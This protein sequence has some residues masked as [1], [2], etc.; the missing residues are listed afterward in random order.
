MTFLN[1]ISLSDKGAIAGVRQIDDAVIAVGSTTLNS[2]TAAFSAA[3][4]GKA[5]SIS[6][7]G[8]SGLKLLTTIVAVISANSVTLANA[9]VTANSSTG[10]TIGFDC[11]TALQ[12]AFDDISAQGG[13]IVVIDGE[14]LLS[15]PVSVNFGGVATDVTVQGTG[16]NSGIYVAAPSGAAAVSISNTAKLLISDII[17]VGTPLERND[18]FRVLN[19]V[20][21]R[22]E[23]RSCS[24]YGLAAFDQANGGIVYAS[25]STLLLADSRFLGCT[26]GASLD[27]SVV[28]NRSFIS[29]RAERNQFIDFGRLNGYYHSKTG[30]GQPLGWIRVAD[31]S[32]NN[33][34]EQGIASYQVW[35]TGNFMDENSLRGVIVSPPGDQTIAQVHIDS[36]QANVSTVAG[37][38]GVYL[39]RVRYATIQESAFTLASELRNAIYLQTCGDVE[40]D[41]IQITREPRGLFAANCDSVTLRN[42]PD[43]NS[44]TLNAVTRF[45]RIDH[46]VGGV[47]PFSK[48]GVVSDADFDA[49]PAIGTLALDLSGPDIFFRGEQGWQGLNT[50][51]MPW[52]PNVQ[53]QGGV[54]TAYTTDCCY[55]VIGDVCEVQI[56][57]TISDNGSGSSYLR[58]S[59]PV[60]P[61]LNAPLTGRNRVTNRL[62]SAEANVN[63]SKIYI[64][65]YAGGYP[66]ASGQVLVLQGRYR[67]R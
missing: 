38:T 29:F 37:A 4:V 15:T 22:V 54:I 18:A 9:A 8:A 39:A 45:I 57:I 52:N 3:D 30:F 28:E 24:F 21:C 47:V 43:L 42:S 34:T 7:A 32:L 46:S 10:A 5:I 67:V 58:A 16:S 23:I 12:A 44:L 51:W 50:G 19:L 41:T 64:Y 35:L 6:G 65:D 17:F 25:D 13:G 33:P 26:A 20:A 48:N 61:S 1:A 60:A 53:A 2:A 14:Y 11:G 63:D 49:T 56:Q 55:R 59:L 40:I 27:C 36:H 66:V 62:L 31:V